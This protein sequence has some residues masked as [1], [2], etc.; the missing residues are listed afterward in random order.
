LHFRKCKS[1]P[2]GSFTCA[3]LKEAQKLSDKSVKHLAGQLVSI[4]S[5]AITP[6]LID[7]VRVSCDGQ[8]TPIRHLATTMPDGSRI[9]VRPF[10]PDLLGAIAAALQRD[11]FT[12]Y[13][14]SK[15]TVVVTTASIQTQAE[16]EKVVS[17]VRKLEEEAKIA[18]RNVRK[19]IRQGLSKDDQKQLD[20]QLQTLTDECIRKIEAMAEAKI[21]SL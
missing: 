12:A 9:A 3:D 2:G 4:R 10:D 17:C 7:N 8:L 6:G 19:K 21:A 5:G 11:G 1:S 13:V 16:R 15:T 18:V 20:G 14:F